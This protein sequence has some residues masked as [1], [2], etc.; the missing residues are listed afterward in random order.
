MNNLLKTALLS[1]ALSAALGSTAMADTATASL[2]V[3]ATV[4]KACRVT[5]NALSFGNY[6]PTGS[7]ALDASTTISVLC[8][9]G[10]SYTVGLDAGGGGSA[11]VSA[12][13]MTS[14][15]NTLNYALYQN[16]SRTT[17][18]GNT[19]GTDTPAATT[20]GSSAQSH[21]IYGR[22]AANQNVADGAYSDTVTV[23][24]NY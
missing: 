17:N 12:R 1:A 19:G 13:K 18:W 22:V 24:V 8:T 2:P 23:T 15:S 4:Q 16:A 10:T 11:T 3:S 9:N 6:D 5:A 7:T 21:T 20:A 14:G